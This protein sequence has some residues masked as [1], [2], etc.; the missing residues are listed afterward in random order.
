MLSTNLNSR[1]TLKKKK[2]A[3]FFLGS[4]ENK[5]RS[6]AVGIRSFLS[7]ELLLTYFRKGSK[8]T[9]FFYLAEKSN[10]FMD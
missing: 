1:Q 8:E 9:F 10:F 7:S 3:N 2:R 4:G 6:E 5:V